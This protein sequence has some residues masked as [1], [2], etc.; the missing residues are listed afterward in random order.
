[1]QTFIQNFKKQQGVS[2][3]LALMMV[4]LIVFLVVFVSAISTG[5]LRLSGS[6][7][8]SSRAFSAADAGIEFALSRINSGLSVGDTVASCGCDS[9]AWCPST[10]FSSNAQ[11]CVIA[12]NP[13]QPRKITAIGRTTDTN[14]RRSLEIIVP[15]Y[16][17]MGTV[18]TICYD[19][20]GSVQ[21]PNS[22]CTSQTYNGATGMIGVTASDCMAASG[23]AIVSM[24]SSIAR[25]DRTFTTV[26][27]SYYLV[28]CYK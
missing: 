26:G 4:T 24:N 2:L 17:A 18:S 7:V 1:M 6:A 5:Q 8:D 22:M 27:S 11:Y 13:A 23:G 14:I 16:A 19:G 25:S 10:K 9:G 3:L 21:S 28:Q 12:D 20:D 15:V